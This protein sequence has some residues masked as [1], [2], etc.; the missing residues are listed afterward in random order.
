MRSQHPLRLRRSAA[1]VLLTFAGCA[2]AVVSGGKVNL[3]RTEQIYSDVQELRELNFKTEVPLAPMDRDQA[4]LVLERE[5]ARH[6]DTARLRRAAEVGELTGL[7]ASATDLKAQTLRALSSRIVGFYD[8]QDREMI[9]IKGNSRPSLWSEITG[10]FSSSHSTDE[11]LIAH[12][13]THALQDQYFGIDNALGRIID[14]DDRALALKSVAE[15]DATLVG[16]GYISGYLDAG[17]I[18]KLL[19]HIEDMPKL[20]EVQATDMPAALRDSL[21]FQ[22]T[23]GTRFVAEVYQH[24]G[25]NAVN[26]LYRKPPLSTRQVLEPALYLGHSSPPLAITV[27]GWAPALK[28]WDKVAENTY[29]ELLLRVI[30]TRSPGSPLDA[31]LARGWRGDRMVVLQKDGA[32]TVI[33]IVALSDYTSAAGFART[34]EGILERSASGGAPP[35]HHVERRGTAVLAIIGPGAVRSAELAPAVWRASAIDAAAPGA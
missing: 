14:N 1:L 12:E 23:D 11:I 30:L 31:G 34:Y 35:P 9:L 18:G 13:L 21:I 29:G 15:G 22:Y 26:A 7:Y 27:G 4:N 10:F 6:Q 5:L 20:F 24:G 8:P 17:I 28:G 25:W 19:T 32:V 3:Q 33:W 16:Y 2:Y